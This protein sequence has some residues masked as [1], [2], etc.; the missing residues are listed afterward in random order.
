MVFVV[1]KESV[2]PHFGRMRAEFWAAT[3]GGGGSGRKWARPYVVPAKAGTYTLCHRDLAL[4]VETFSNNERSGVWVPAF[5][6][7]TR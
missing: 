1:G 5:A 7:T 2:G 4:E 6:G 3:G